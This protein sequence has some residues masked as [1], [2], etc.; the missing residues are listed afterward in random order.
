MPRWL[1]GATVRYT[2][3][4]CLF[5]FAALLYANTLNN[6]FTLDDRPL[7]ERNPLIR[8]LERIPTLFTSDYWYPRL[9][10]GLYRPLVMTTYSL[11]F[12]VGGRQP[13]GYHM[14]NVG[15]H[16]LVSVLVWA[17]Y[18]RLTGDGLTAGAAGFLFAAHAIHTEAV[19]NVIG[20]A[21]LLAA[22]LFLLSFFS[23]IGSRD[24]RGQRRAGLYAASLAVYLLGLLSKEGVVTLVGV[25][26]LYDFVHGDGTARSL[27]P[28]LWEVARRGWRVYTGYVLVTVLYL[29][30]R[31]L[32]LGGVK[33][34][35]PMIM[36][37][38]PLVMLDLPW[39]LLNAL[40]VSFRYLGLLFFPL[41]LS[42]DYSYNHIPMLSSLADPR[43]WAVLG[44]CAML[45]GIVVWSYRAW[46][47]LFFLLGFY[48]ATFSVVSNLVVLIGTIMGERL[49]Y[50]PSVAFC[51]A[52]V[53]VL[54]GLCRRLP[55][56]PTAARTVFVGVMVLG[57]GL[58]SARTLIRNPNW[59]SHER[60]YLHDVEVV[61]G[62]AKALNNAAALLWGKKK[63]YEKA[64]EFFRRSI[65]ITPQYYQAYRTSGFVYTEL[66][67]DDEAMEMYDL[68]IRY[69][70]GDAKVYNNLGYILVDK[71]IEMQRGIALLEKAVK[72]RPKNY[73]FLDSLGWGYYKQG[74]LEEA[75]KML[76]KS[77]A[78]NQKS[79]S[80]PSRRAH[81]KEIEE[82]LRRQEKKPAS[83]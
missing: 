2:V 19:A 46:K 1:R 44:L 13:R 50:M 23:Y 70:G 60:L 75:R 67:R 7:V 5:L 4:L 35:P 45:I 25:I 74:R 9:T 18:R 12:A 14:A 83:P 47:E 29:G 39:R 43:T 76:R 79:A 10:S 82:A 52:L 57:V 17:L 51:L 42:Y 63:E 38:N 78:L 20:R 32:A 41:H 27:I 16:A 37:D 64:L 56:A 48:F 53:L 58:H 36:M 26:F 62:S 61:P 59:E 22:L 73:E 8:R 3:P 6:G 65:A 34:L 49:V 33:T 15:L 80:T 28:R 40:Q 68:A 55:L 11:N 30:I 21:E 31:M 66:G 81:L 24:A 72:K 69:G 71:G 77:L 54:R